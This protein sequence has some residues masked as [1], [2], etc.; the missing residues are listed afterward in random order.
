MVDVS[1]KFN[2]HPSVWKATFFNGNG[3]DETYPPL[4]VS[5]GCLLFN[6][7][8]KNDSTYDQTKGQKYTIISKNYASVSCL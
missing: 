4:D 7:L 5:C 1:A 2:L 6:D 3:L 8:A